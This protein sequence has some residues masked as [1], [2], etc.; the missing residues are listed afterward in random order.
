MPGIVAAF[1]SG[2]GRCARGVAQQTSCD[3]EIAAD[4]VFAAAMLS[5]YRAS[6]E[7]FGPWFYRRLYW[8]TGVIGQVLYLEAEASGIR[9]TGIGCFFDDLTHRVFGLTGDRFQ[10][11]YHFTMGGPVEDPRLQTHSPYQHLAR[12]ARPLALTVEAC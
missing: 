7:A 5:E 12:A 11:L 1:L 3:Q 8:E 9:G 2:S 10:V 4:G 6:L